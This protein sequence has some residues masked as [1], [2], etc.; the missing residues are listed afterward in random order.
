MEF[1]LRINLE[2]DAFQPEPGPEIVRLLR[3]C[4]DRLERF[5]SQTVTMCD[6]NGNQALRA[7]IREVGPEPFEAPPTDQG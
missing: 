4:A 1:L 6:V 2:N 3:A 7:A 5:G